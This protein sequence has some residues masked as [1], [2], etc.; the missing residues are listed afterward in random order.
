M[1]RDEKKDESVVVTRSNI[2]VAN[3]IV[4]IALLVLVLGVLKYIG[5]SP[6]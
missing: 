5:A 2:N 3:I 4:A 6:F 1:N